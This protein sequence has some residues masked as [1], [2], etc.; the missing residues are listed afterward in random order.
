MPTCHSSRPPVRRPLAMQPQHSSML[1][2][3]ST[4]RS[5]CSHMVV[6]AAPEDDREVV[7]NKEFGYSRKDVLI[8]IV[9]LIALGV[10]MYEGL[11]AAGMSPGMAGNWVQLLIFLGICVG[12]VSTYLYRV[13][14]KQMTYA[15]QLRMYEEAVMQKRLDEM[16]E[17]ELQQLLQEVEM[18]KDQMQVGQ[19]QVAQQ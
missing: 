9:A 17:A 3:G 2:Q 7:Y 4:T 15:Q 13:A 18:D 16:T 6:R 14:N 1:L 12:W 11:Q 10:F 5:R 8:I 19:Q